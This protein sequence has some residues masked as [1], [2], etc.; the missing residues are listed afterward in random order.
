MAFSAVFVSLSSVAGVSRIL[1]PRQILNLEGQVVFVRD[2]AQNLSGMVVLTIS[3]E[4]SYTSGFNILL[5]LLL[6]LFVSLASKFS[7]PVY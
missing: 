3:N 6:L 1:T 7:V 4:R 5:L 2:P